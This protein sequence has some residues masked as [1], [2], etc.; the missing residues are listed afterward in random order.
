LPGAISWPSSACCAST[1]PSWTC[2]SPPRHL[3]AGKAAAVKHL[4]IRRI[5][6]SMD[7]LDPARFRDITGRDM[8]DRVLAAIDECL[9]LGLRV[10]INVVAMKGV[11]DAELPAFVRLACDKLWTC[12]SSSSCPSAPPRAGAT[13]PPGR[14]RKLSNRPE[15]WSA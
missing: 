5:N 7:T 9:G 8:L 1:A 6:I 11:N 12:A 13:Q 14:Q 2:A 15:P 4:G 3:L 10:K